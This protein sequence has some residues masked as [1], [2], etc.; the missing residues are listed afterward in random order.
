MKNLKSQVENILAFSEKA[1]NNDADLIIELYTKF[2]YLSE[3][4][5]VNKLRDIMNYAKPD[6]IVRYRRRFNQL[7]LY[8]TS[9]LKV[10]EERDKK[11][12]KMT[13]ILGY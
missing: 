12:I 8:K 7:H 1:R 13:N 2:Y 11:R 3:K 5:D 10:L 4:I 6:E 9:D